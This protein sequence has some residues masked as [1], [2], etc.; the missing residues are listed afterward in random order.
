MLKSSIVITNSDA[1]TA[2]A[3][4]ISITKCSLTRLRY[5]VSVTTEPYSWERYRSRFYLLGL[6]VRSSHPPKEIVAS[7]HNHF[8]H[9][10]ACKLSLVLPGRDSV[11]QSTVSL[12]RSVRSECAMF[13]AR[14]CHLTACSGLHSRTGLSMREF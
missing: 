10:K 11:Y 7:S 9:R 14:F 3:S 1:I 5:F 8:L 13:S 2:S 4:R 12:N 6:E